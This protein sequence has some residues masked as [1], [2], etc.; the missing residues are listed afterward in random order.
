MTK[1][2]KRLEEFMDGLKKRNPGEDEFHQ[3]VLEVELMSN[4]VFRH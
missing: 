1:K 3:A 2:S 4:L